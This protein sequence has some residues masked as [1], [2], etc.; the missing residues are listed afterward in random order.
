MLAAECIGWIPPVQYDFHDNSLIRNMF[1]PLM[2]R[3]ARRLF[4]CCG[5]LS[6]HSL[7]ENLNLMLRRTT[8]ILFP[9]FLVLGFAACS[10]APETPQ[11]R[12]TDITG[13]P[14]GR[15]LAL[16]DH[17]GKPRTLGD[18]RGKA[19]LLFFGYSQCPDV[20][21]TAMTRFAQTLTR[22]GP[23]A[24]RVQVLFVT[25]DPER[26]TPELLGKYVPFFHPGFLGLTGTLAETDAAAREFRVFYAKRKADGALGYSVDHWTGA[27]ALD[28]AGRLRLYIAPERSPDEIA[29][30]LRQ[31]LAN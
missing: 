29:A 23:D 17:H 18:F 1:L 2:L 11:F 24:D 14:F 3:R 19:I 28:A 5:S 22:L 21:P 25:L 31:L 4:V 13:S 30:D 16:T 8:V 15:Q 12:S 26:D 9:L 7:A 6:G 27:Y 20:C 10:K